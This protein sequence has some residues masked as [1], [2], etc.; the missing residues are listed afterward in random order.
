MINMQVL[1]Q[2]LVTY[3]E[4]AFTEEGE[5]QWGLGNRLRIRHLLCQTHHGHH[6]AGTVG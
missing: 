4:A 6:P 3:E 2:S 5:H 1:V